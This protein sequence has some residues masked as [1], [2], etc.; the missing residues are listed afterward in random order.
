MRLFQKY[1][2]I[3][4]TRQ[5]CN[6][7]HSTDNC[8]NNAVAATLPSHENDAK[9]MLLSLQITLHKSTIRI[10]LSPAKYRECIRWL[11]RATTNGSR[12]IAGHADKKKIITPDSLECRY[13]EGRIQPGELRL[14]GRHPTMRAASMW[15]ASNHESCD[16]VGRI[17]PCELRLCGVH[18]TMRAATMWGASN[19]ASCDYV[20]WIQPCELRQCAEHT[21]TLAVHTISPRTRCSGINK[22]LLIK[23]IS[24]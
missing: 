7:F 19:H 2:K 3:V 20:G 5:N 16:Y 24:L 1:H 8:G 4:S 13:Y 21:T 11:Q 18:P 9:R 23:I 10:H 6:V 22:V 12:G 15:G 14:C 17:Q